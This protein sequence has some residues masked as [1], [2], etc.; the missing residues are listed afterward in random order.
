VTTGSAMRDVTRKEQ[1]TKVV[2]RDLE[3]M[4]SQRLLPGEKTLEKVAGDEAPLSRGPY[5][6]LHELEPP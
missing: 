1:A 6:A 4:S 5:E 3:W 2:E